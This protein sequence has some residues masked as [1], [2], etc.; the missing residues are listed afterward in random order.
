MRNEKKGSEDVVQREYERRFLVLDL[1]PQIKDNLETYRYIDIEQG[2]LPLGTRIRKS[3]NQNGNIS[4]IMVDKTVVG[5]DGI[6]RDEEEK[7]ISAKEFRKL[8]RQTKGARIFKRRYF[9]ELAE[10][11]IELDIF[12]GDFEGKMLAE[13]EFNSHERALAFNPL[14]WFGREVTREVSNRKLA[15]GIPFPES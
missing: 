13:L 15:L 4:Y 11:I 8:W 10:L 1:P 2:Y 3:V 5:T 7:T 6:A 14:D 9:I 12:K